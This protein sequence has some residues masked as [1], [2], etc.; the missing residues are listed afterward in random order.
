MRGGKARFLDVQS[1]LRKQLKAKGIADP[2]QWCAD[3]GGGLDAALA[4]TVTLAADDVLLDNLLARL[5]DQPLAHKL[6][7]GA[8]SFANR[9][10]S[11]V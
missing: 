6:L 5:D 7:I 9:S 2:A 4:E 3:P 10:T 1:R 11:Q 8:R